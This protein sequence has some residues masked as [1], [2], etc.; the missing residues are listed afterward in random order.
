MPALFQAGVLVVSLPVEAMNAKN[1]L[2]QK[3]RVMVTGEPGGASDEG[4]FIGSF[5]DF[6]L[7]LWR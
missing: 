2:K 6:G 7:L 3:L 4:F 5:P 1:L